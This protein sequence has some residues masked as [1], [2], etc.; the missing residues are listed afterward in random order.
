MNLKRPKRIAT[1]ICALTLCS[2]LLMSLSANAQRRERLNKS[3]DPASIK[4][5]DSTQA[6]WGR[7]SVNDQIYKGVPVNATYLE[8]GRQRLP[9][10]FWMY[11]PKPI[12]TDDLVGPTKKTSPP[13]TIKVN[14]KSQDLK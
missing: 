12:S 2:V 6:Q 13:A 8:R 9:D 14:G 3:E 5:M 11:K 7:R 1:T 4:F 10:T